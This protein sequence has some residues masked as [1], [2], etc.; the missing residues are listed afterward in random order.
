V[1]I[2]ASKVKDARK[3]PGWSERRLIL[4]AVERAGLQVPRMG[5]YGGMQA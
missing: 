3:L 5:W 4:E 1:T 2:A